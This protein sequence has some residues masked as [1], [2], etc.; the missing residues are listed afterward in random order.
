[1]YDNF[2]FTYSIGRKTKVDLVKIKEVEN[3]FKNEYII[4][5]FFNFN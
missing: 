5:N 3:F 1:M 4:L 2:K